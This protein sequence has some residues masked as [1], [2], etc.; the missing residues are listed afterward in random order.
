MRRMTFIVMIIGLFLV[1][2]E[3]KAAKESVSGALDSFN[4]VIPT[5]TELT[6][7]DKTGSASSTPAAANQTPQATATVGA[8]I[9]ESVTSAVLDLK[10][11]GTKEIQQALKNANLYDGKIDGSSGPKTKNAIMKFQEQNGLNADGKVGAK[12]WAKLGSFLNQ[13][14]EP[15][16][17]SLKE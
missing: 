11:V 8:T 2:C 10:S 6:L 1:G 16:T 7:M 4:Q 3:K 9:P 17:E 5:Q 13:T 15:Q 12:T 14:A